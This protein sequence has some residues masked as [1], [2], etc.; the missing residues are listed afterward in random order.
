VFKPE[1]KALGTAIAAIAAF[2]LHFFPKLRSAFVPRKGLRFWTALPWFLTSALALLLVF[3][4]IPARS[5]EKDNLI[6]QQ[7]NLLTRAWL[8]WQINLEKAA[9][10][11]SE[12]TGK[13]D[14][15]RGAEKKAKDQSEREKAQ[16]D[17]IRWEKARDNCL[18]EKL[19][20]VLRDNQRPPGGVASELMAGQLMLANENTSE[21]LWDR[22]SIDDRFL[23]EGFSVPRGGNSQAARV[24]E[25][26]VPN[27]TDQSPQVWHWEIDQGKILNQKPVMEWP[28]LYVLHNVRPSNHADFEQNWRQWMEKHFQAND[29]P[30]LL[31]RFAMLDKPSSG[32]IGRSDTARVFMS[33]LRELSSKTLAA[34]SLSTGYIKNV[35]SGEKGVKVHIWVY[36][37]PEN[38]EVMRATWGGVLA[39]FGTWITEEPCKIAR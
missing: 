30:P 29:P 34:A 28:L 18:S 6:K 5:K 20:P 9:S 35:K 25:Y 23:G 8:N 24:P 4:V 2:T 31:V 39:N 27:L 12:V 22:L 14:A 11:C 38:D 21:A 16:N 26:L 1:A 15:A 7:E 19:K 37:P 33:E 17:E 36:A 32:C 13:V 3:K 10:Q